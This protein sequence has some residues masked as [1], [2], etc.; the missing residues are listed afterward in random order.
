MERLLVALVLVVVAVAVAAVLQRRRP[1]A[2]SGANWNVPAQ[3][4]RSDFRS[5]SSPWLVAVFTS[6]TC[7]A[8]SDVAMKAGA[9]ESTSVAVQELEVTDDAE[10]HRRYGIDAVPLVL[11]ADID[12]VVLRHFLGPVTATDLWAAVAEAR[13][14]GS[15]PESCHD[16]TD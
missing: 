9:L 11:I 4:D 1:A 16:H 15:T 14:P 3:L 10:L 7:T 2:P 6:A 12:G 8:C 5:P 13:E